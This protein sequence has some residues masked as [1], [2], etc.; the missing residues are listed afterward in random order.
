MRKPYRSDGSNIPDEKNLCQGLV[1]G[2]QGLGVYPECPYFP[3]SGRSIYRERFEVRNALDK[4]S[5]HWEGNTGIPGTLPSPAF[6]RQALDRGS[7]HQVYLIRRS[8]MVF[9]YYRK[10]LIKAFHSGFPSMCIH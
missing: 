3:P 8:D 1:D 7:F 10:Q 2:M 5:G 6:H 9:A 4:S